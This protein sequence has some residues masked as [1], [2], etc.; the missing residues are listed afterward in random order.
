MDLNSSWQDEEDGR[1][2]SGNGSLAGSYMRKMEHR[3]MGADAVS[4][5][6]AEPIALVEGGAVEAVVSDN[7]EGSGGNSSMGQHIPSGGDHRTAMG[8]GSSQRDGSGGSSSTPTPLLNINVEFIKPF[9]ELVSSCSIQLQKSLHSLAQKH[10]AHILFSFQD[11]FIEGMDPLS[12][13][14]DLNH[15]LDL[16]DAL[17]QFLRTFGVKLVGLPALMQLL[18][19]LRDYWHLLSK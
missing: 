15:L 3:I 6:A 17:E 14:D 9:Q 7:D 4:R 1:V 11:G 10:L 5:R 2:G 18:M 13:P 16:Y 12:D 8:E 19:R